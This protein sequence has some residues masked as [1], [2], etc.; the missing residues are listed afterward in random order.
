MSEE[1]MRI[2]RAFLQS[3]REQ[4]ANRDLVIVVLLLAI[5]F[6]LA[7]GIIGR[8][9]WAKNIRYVVDTIRDKLNKK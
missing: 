5:F 9:I 1:Q 2:A 4:S 3:M 8:P 7:F 6:M